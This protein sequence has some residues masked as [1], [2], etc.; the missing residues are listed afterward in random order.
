MSGG[1]L[2][3]FSMFDLFK[4]EVE[5][6][7]QSMNQALIALEQTP[8]DVKLIEPL[9][10]GAHSIKGAARIVGLDLAVDLAHAMEDAF[11]AAQE[12]KAAVT[13]GAIDCFF[14]GVDWIDRFS[15]VPEA[16]SPAWQEENR[17]PIQALVWQYQLIKAGKEPVS[18][19]G[20]AQGGASTAAPS[21]TPTKEPAPAPAPVVITPPQDLGGFSMME[22]F[23]AEIDQHGSALNKGL[24]ALE[25]NP[26]DMKLIEPL[27][28][29]AHSIKG[30]ARI[31]GLDTAVELAHA[32]EDVFSGA[33]HGEVKINARAIDWLLKGVDRL[34]QISQQTDAGLPGW[35]ASN[36]DG[37]S[38]LVKVFK[39]IKAGK[40][41][42]G[43]GG[44]A[45]APAAVKAEEKPAAATAAAT[46][47]SPAPATTPM[48]MTTTP[49]ADDRAVRVSAENLNRLMGLAGESM[50]DTRR[51]RP[52]IESLLHLKRQQNRLST[53]L[54]HLQDSIEMGAHAD[55]L[56]AITRDAQGIAKA[57]RQNLMGQLERLES[58]ARKTDDLASRLYSE[59]I[60]SR[61]R[62]FSDG[63]GGF[64]R[65]VRDLSRKL[66]KKV[67][68]VIKGDRTQVD[69]DILERIEAPINHMVRNAI[70]HG[71]ELPAERRLRGKPETG[72]ITVE[73]RHWA[74]MLTVTI[75]DDGKGIDPEAIRRKVIAKRMVPADVAA[76]LTDNELFDFMF[77]PGFS[78]AE[79]VSEISGRGVGLDVVQTF[80]QEVSGTVRVTS[81]LGKGS[82]FTLTLPIT[83]SVI[84]AVVVDIAGEPY[85][86]PMT[87][88]DRV[89]HLNV[90]DVT[91]IE[92]RQSYSRDGV[93]IGLIPGA[94]VLG[95]DSPEPKGKLCVVV[96]SDR[97][98]PYGLVV[99][100]FVGEQ[101]LVVR[102][103]DPRLGKL[104]DIAAAALMEDGSPLLIIDTDDMLRSIDKLLHG[105]RL[106]AVKTGLQA[107]AI[108]HKRV[109]VV[110]DSITVREVER[111]LLENRGYQVEIAVDGVDGL[112]AVRDG[113][114]DLVISDVDMPRMTGLE[115]VATI[116]ADPKLKQIPVMIV[117]Y[118]DREED[119]LK[120]L[121]AGANAYLTK[122][123]FHD[124]T[125][126]NMVRDLIGEPEA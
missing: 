13:P 103:L 11:V 81:Q 69:R 94:Q 60:A 76:S 36:A 26:E 40:E 3:G 119:R 126:I 7:S 35:L 53:V 104:P 120:G 52:L 59:A 24:V 51:F 63:V 14:Q 39:Q 34:E 44:E 85:A 21:A 113:H 61:M 79:K 97:N 17:Q 16:E 123:S 82:T 95:F 122:G 68:L 73:A 23:K 15:K 45:A 48:T 58:F 30:A 54:E 42:P 43:P 28:R 75:A 6:N 125:L 67:K 77:L 1:D 62:P 25:Q 18:E 38:E 10:R 88:I 71:M 33:Q 19:R 117:S 107:S 5:Q 78:T 124:Q 57:A 116:K 106:G 49:A 105:G 108:R 99:D 12:G 96:V 101:D 115:L 65:T 50:V 109:L 98:Q 89:E 87:R 91:R 114:F 4:A 64:P 70:D 72:T 118:K 9:M 46:S 90:D 8:G 2:S 100:K 55:S 110:D 112:N 56:S 37:L 102:K 47:P 66:E 31:V 32:M 121:E 27:M 92:N 29:S 80:V 93:N 83:L 86:F 20:R 22:L 41:A 84:R 74:G 111:K